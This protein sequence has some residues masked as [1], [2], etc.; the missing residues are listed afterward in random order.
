MLAC[1]LLFNCSVQTELAVSM[2]LG[3]EWLHFA[4][5]HRGLCMCR[6]GQNRIYTPYTTVYL[7][8]FLPK[9]P[10]I[11]RIY[12]VLADPTYASIHCNVSA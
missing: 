12:M 3:A 4:S 10:Y 2:F 1:F 8:I 7:V 11:H 5:M 9:I 6:V